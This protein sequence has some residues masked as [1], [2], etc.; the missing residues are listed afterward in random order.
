MKTSPKIVNADD[1][2]NKRLFVMAGGTGG[3]VF[4][5][6]AVAKTLAQQGWQIRWLGTADRM[7][8]DLVP[9]HGFEIDFI[10][11]SGLVGSGLKRKLLAPFMILKAILQAKKHFD[12]WQPDV[13]LGMGGY[14]CGPGG[15]AAY[16]S[17]IPLVIHEQNAVAGLTNQWLSRIAKQVLQAFP[18]AFSGREVVGNPVRQDLCQLSHNK[19]K[20]EKAP[21]NILVM[22]G[23]QGAQI[24]NQ[25]LPQA[26][27]LLTSDFAVR[28][29]AGKGRQM[30]TE[31]AYQTEQI[32][33]AEVIEFIDD[34]ASA[35]AWADVLICRSGA[36]TV[37][38]VAVV[39]IPA[40][41][42]PFQH[43][44]RQQALNAEYLVNAGAALMIEQ[45]DLTPEKLAQYLISLDEEKRMAM[46]TA[47]RACAIDD[48]AQRVAHVIQKIVNERD[49]N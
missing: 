35:Y 3:H 48:A 32:K 21:L 2:K 34:V 5:G 14:V 6:I 16:L 13:V 49:P 18:T 45:A 36:L 8:A 17:G 1:M 12:A 38:E 40:I 28:H 41:F 9:N 26:L 31:Q 15:I 29:Q 33:H 10:E 37:S 19:A 47:A 42:V 27:A 4:P 11:V 46:S 30:E 25:T 44:D 24:L 22:G 39:G 43:Q 7:E 20:L 23:S